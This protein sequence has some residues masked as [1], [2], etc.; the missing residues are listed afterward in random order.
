MLSINSFC[1]EV[2]SRW[3]L[4]GLAFRCICAPHATLRQAQIDCVAFSSQRLTSE[5]LSQLFVEVGK[6]RTTRDELRPFRAAARRNCESL[7]S[8]CALTR[9]RL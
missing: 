9:P 7:L 4:P 6:A 1:N 8:R 2:G 3:Q 5:R